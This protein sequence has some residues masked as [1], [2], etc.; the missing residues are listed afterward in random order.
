MPL[1]DTHELLVTRAL[2][3]YGEQELSRLSLSLI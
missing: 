3:E 1:D 2:V